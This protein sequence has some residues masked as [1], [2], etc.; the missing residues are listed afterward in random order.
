M[1]TN[2]SSVK[3]RDGTSR[4][5]WERTN[6]IWWQTWNKKPTDIFILL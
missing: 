4:L 2:K 3:S 5:D 6:Y 1:V